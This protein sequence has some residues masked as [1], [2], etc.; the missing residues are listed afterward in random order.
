[1]THDRTD[2]G[3]QFRNDVFRESVM[4]YGAVVGAEGIVTEDGAAGT[5]LSGDR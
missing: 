3:M 2:E 5:V 4:E 1:M